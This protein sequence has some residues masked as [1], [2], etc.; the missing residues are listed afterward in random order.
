MDALGKL[1]LNCSFPEMR[2]RDPLQ[3]LSNDFMRCDSRAE[4][5]TG[6]PCNGLLLILYGSGTRHGGRGSDAYEILCIQALPYAPYQHGHIRPLAAPIGMQLIKDKVLQITAMLHDP[7]VNGFI[8]GKDELE[9][10]EVGQQN[11]RGVLGDVFSEIL[12]L[13]PR[14]P[15]N[16]K[17]LF[18]VREPM[19]KFVEFLYLTVGQGVHRIDD[20]G[21]CPRCWVLFLCLEDMINYGDEEG[22]GFTRP[23]TGCNNI[24]LSFPGLGNGLNLMFEQL[25]G[26]CFPFDLANLKYV[27]AS[28][29]EKTL[30]YKRLNRVFAFIIGI[31]LNERFRPVPAIRV[32]L[33]HRCQEILGFDAC[34]AAR[35]SAVLLNQCVTK[36]KYI[37]HQTI[38]TSR[39]EHNE[40]MNNN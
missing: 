12:F 2:I 22:Q 38:P 1:R 5:L 33:I 7:P 13:L 30:R 24:A 10:H 35:E 11:I 34:E 39:P 40:I 20:Y 3:G 17:G 31:Y 36:F 26:T 29:V 23:G 21:P 32:C 16:G 9:H 8:A 28:L 18:L 15:G 27:G 4:D 6:N 25:Q 19:E 37:I 14:I